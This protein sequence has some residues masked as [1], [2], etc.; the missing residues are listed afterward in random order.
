LTIIRLVACAFNEEE[1]LTSS[2]LPSEEPLLEPRARVPD[3]FFYGRLKSESRSEPN[4]P[5]YSY[6]AS[7]AW[8]TPD[9]SGPGPF[10]LHYYRPTRFG[11][12]SRWSTS[13][14]G[15][16]SA[17]PSYRP[18]IPSPRPAFGQPSVFAERRR[19]PSYPWFN[20]PRPASPI[21][22]PT[23][24]P[25]ATVPNYF[26]FAAPATAL[27]QPFSWSQ[28]AL[29]PIPVSSH[30]H[31]LAD[32][33]VD[34]DG[35]SPSP[36]PVQGEVT[37]GPGMS[38]LG[39]DQQVLIEQDVEMAPPVVIDEDVLRRQSARSSERHFELKPEASEGQEQAGGT[40]Q[41]GRTSGG[42][43]G[44]AGALDATG[45]NAPTQGGT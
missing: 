42:R 30:M 31:S 3:I 41:V 14:S 4:L 36:L 33:I 15:T 34:C 16:S 11:I 28:P 10:G 26:A 45:G 22:A 39:A 1:N 17:W 7:E 9:R 27:P 13:A 24:K 25:G 5:A 20:V 32:D 19:Q 21:F 43:V 2:P 6:T 40:T 38:Y 8:F 35:P 12:S 29:P 44:G 18:L 37:L 23:P